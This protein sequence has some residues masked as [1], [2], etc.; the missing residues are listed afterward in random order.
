MWWWLW[1][2]WARQQAASTPTT[3]PSPL[4]SAAWHRRVVEL[5]EAL[6]SPS[7]DRA[8]GGS[9]I[10]RLSLC[11]PA[12]LAV[13]VCCQLQLNTQKLTKSIYFSEAIWNIQ[14]FSR[15]T[16]SAGKKHYLNFQTIHIDHFY[17]ALFSALDQTHCTHAT[18]DS[19]LVIVSFLYSKLFNIHQLFTDSSIWLLH[20]WCHVKLLLFVL[21][22]PWHKGCCLCWQ[23]YQTQVLFVLTRP[24]NQGCC[25]CWPDHQ[26]QSGC[27]C[28]PDHKT[29][30]VVCVDQTTKTRVVVCVDQTTKPGLLF[31]LTRPPKPGLLFVLMWPQDQLFVLIWPPNRGYCCLCWQDHQIGVICVCD[32]HQIGVIVCVDMATK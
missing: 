28:W 8:L 32:D 31:V 20:G 11:M 5:Q 15:D 14:R 17:I 21:A 6:S 18:C 12:E 19:E 22:W 26:N 9:W 4:R 23:D 3:Q 24:P 27:L 2:R 1:I 16:L 25:L 29:R 7:L 13:K 10:T 30:V